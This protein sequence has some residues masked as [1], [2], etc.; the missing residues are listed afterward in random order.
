MSNIEKLLREMV[1]QLEP[2]PAKKSAARASHQYLRSMMSTGG[3]GDRIVDS[4]LSGS[5]ARN[6][7]VHPL[8]D[9]D[10]IFLIDASKWPGGGLLGWGRPNP[11][12]VLHSFADALRYRYSRSSAFQQRRSIRLELNHLHIDCVPAIEVSDSDYILV[13]D[14]KED[15]WI[16][17][18]PKMHQAALTKANQLCA[19]CAVPAVKLLKAWNSS[20]PSTVCLRSFVIETIAVT[21]LT[22]VPRGTLEECVLA[23]FDFLALF[24]NDAALLWD[25]K[26][27]ISLDD[28]S[29]MMVPD[30]AQTGANVAGG[31]DYAQAGRLLDH[32]IRSRDALLSARKART[33][34]SVAKHVLAALR[35]N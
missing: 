24:R 27:G 26:L 34:A 20:L 15:K 3:L 31:V 35:W 25:G 13:G 17:S 5:Y 14:R 8:R 28:W 33:E 11:S 18:S 22:A 1:S 7:A 6:T 4:Y 32:A 12:T 19:G 30:L 10:V 9:V 23:F 2:S 16:K 29:G 21:A